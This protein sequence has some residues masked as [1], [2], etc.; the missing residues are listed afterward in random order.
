MACRASAVQIVSFPVSLHQRGSMSLPLVKAGKP[1][2][3]AGRGAVRAARYRRMRAWKAG[4]CLAEVEAGVQIQKTGEPFSCGRGELG[5][6]PDDCH[7]QGTVKDQVLAG[8]A[9]VSDQNPWPA[10]A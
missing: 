3:G 10:Q 4:F 1:R 7:I 9:G 2:G 8:K 5:V 6:L